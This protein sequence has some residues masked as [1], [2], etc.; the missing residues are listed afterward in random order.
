MYSMNLLGLIIL[1]MTSCGP[2]ARTQQAKTVPETPKALQ[3]KTDVSFVSYKRR[4]QGIV[5]SLYDELAAKNEKLIKL[6]EH[7]SDIAEKAAGINQNIE[8]YNE[9]SGNYY[10][11]AEHMISSIDDSLL[12]QKTRE[13]IKISKENQ[14]RRVE[15]MM[16]MREKYEKLTRAAL[17]HHLVMEIALTLPLMERYQKG[18]R[19]DELSMKKLING[20]QSLIRQMDLIS[21]KG[22]E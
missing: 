7:R 4:G 3:E 10:Q 21:E 12:K 2:D 11:N 8:L 6:E 20:Q 19:P 16:E 22:I 15:N 5:E 18:S 13:L 17:D 14:Q 1:A 9:K